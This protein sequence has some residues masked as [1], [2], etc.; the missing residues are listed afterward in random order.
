MDSWVRCFVFCLMFVCCH[1][2]A[3][4][5]QFVCFQFYKKLQGTGHAYAW[6]Q[7]LELMGHVEQHDRCIGWY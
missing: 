5:S 7:K 2:F 3:E 6:H 1:L 4:L